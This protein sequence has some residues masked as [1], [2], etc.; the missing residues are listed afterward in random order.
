MTALR[1]GVATADWTAWTC[2]VRLAVTEPAALDEARAVVAA[3]LA[4]VDRACSRFRP[5]SELAAVDAASGRWTPV[6]PLLAEAL[7]VALRAARLT[8]GDV[9]PTV[10]GA[11]L[12][13][14]YDRDRDRVD[15]GTV[16][17]VL[18]PVAGWWTVELDGDRVRTPWG[19]RL[20]LGATAKAWTADRAAAAVTAR[21]GAGALVSIGGDVAVA[22]P[23]PE[24]GWRIRVEDVTG[25]PDAP[26]PT[27]SAVVSVVDGGLATS[28]TRARRWRRGGVEVHHLVDPRTGQPARPVWRTVSV[29][30]GSCT[31]AN[32]VSTAAVV[33]GHAALPWLRELG[34]PAR[35]V[36]E[37]GDVVTTGGWPA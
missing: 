5:D 8:D 20:D 34:L 37:H 3:E 36:T 35:L 6:G 32:T 16:P 28:G 14:G 18:A 23:A 31:D 21:T 25:D 9:D 11:L 2:R 15:P 4:A 27:G 19:T 13:L 12:A 1:D 7:A 17:P 10:G 29:A 26:A 22:G 24:G 33:R 30:A